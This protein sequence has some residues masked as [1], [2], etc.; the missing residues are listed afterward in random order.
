MKIKGLFIEDKEKVSRFY[1]KKDI[2]FV[3]LSLNR[4]EIFYFDSSW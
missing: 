1:M 2:D 4:D 3:K